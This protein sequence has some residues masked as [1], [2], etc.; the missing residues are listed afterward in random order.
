MSG[1]VLNVDKCRRK[2]EPL[3]FKVVSVYHLVMKFNADHVRQIWNLLVRR[4]WDWLSCRSKSTTSCLDWDECQGTSEKKWGVLK[5][6]VKFWS[7]TAAIA[8]GRSVEIHSFSG[9]QFHLSL[10]LKL[11]SPCALWDCCYT[12]LLVAAPPSLLSLLLTFECEAFCCWNASSLNRCA[13]SLPF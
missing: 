9:G 4:E 11:G 5:K 1:L 8:D 3:D 7:E 13:L 2:C 6:L 10:P 12:V